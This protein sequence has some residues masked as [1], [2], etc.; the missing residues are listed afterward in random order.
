[1]R[2]NGAA[3]VAARASRSAPVRRN[4]TELAH[5]I[6]RFRRNTDPV[7]ISSSCLDSLAKAVPCKYVGVRRRRCTMGQH[8]ASGFYRVGS[9]YSGCDKIQM[10]ADYY[11]TSNGRLL[12]PP[13]GSSNGRTRPR[14]QQC[15]Q[16]VDGYRRTADHSSVT[17]VVS[18]STA[19][20]CRH[21]M[22][23]LRPS[24]S[25]RQPP[26]IDARSNPA[27]ASGRRSCSFELRRN[28][29]AP[30]PIQSSPLRKH[31]TF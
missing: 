19:V 13:R 21:D 25:P 16:P 12:P 2:R 24:G 7:H 22:I 14:C 9:G 29:G 31:S 28:C 26:H 30:S 17:R 8:N 3:N 23:R 20:R 5:V 11:A 27:R 1:M 15:V 4:K 10:S 18:L 6:V